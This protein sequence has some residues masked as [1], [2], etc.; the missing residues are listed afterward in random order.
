MIEGFP[1]TLEAAGFAKLE[2]S[3]TTIGCWVPCTLEV[4]LNGGV[5]G[6]SYTGNTW[7]LG[8]SVDGGFP[9]GPF[10]GTVPSD[11]SNVTGSVAWSFSLKPGTHTV[12]SYVWTEKGA[13][14]QYF[15]GDY[16]VYFP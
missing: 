6:V 12:Q 9:D 13:Y 16:R 15:H 14:L 4:E 1:D 3:P 2:S 5:G 11:L 7:T 8:I 10:I